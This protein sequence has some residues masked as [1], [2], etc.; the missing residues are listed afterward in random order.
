MRLFAFLTAL[1]LVLSVA[2]LVPGCRNA[3][4]PAQRPAA[5][6]KD[7]AAARPVK[8]TL[9]NI[10]N[11]MSDGNVLIVK[12]LLELP[13]LQM[14]PKFRELRQELIAEVKALL[15]E[16]NAA[17][18]ATD[19]GRARLQGE[20]EAVLVRAFGP[21]VAGTID[22]RIKDTKKPAAKEQAE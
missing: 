13:D 15:A 14:K 4:S 21:A 8:V 17:D 7:A 12:V 2:L 6:A 22:L 18:M 20:V 1:T 9:G 16:R 10:A 11:T 3:S 5:E 19:A